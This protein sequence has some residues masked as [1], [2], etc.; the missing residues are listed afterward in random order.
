M[1]TNTYCIQ[2]SILNGKKIRFVY[3]LLFYVFLTSFIE[4]MKLK[5]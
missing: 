3:D 1:E 2:F 4:H 5:C